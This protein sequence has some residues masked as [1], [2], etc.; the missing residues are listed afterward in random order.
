[1]PE[2]PTKQSSGHVTTLAPGLRV[3]RCDNPGPLT[4]TG[5]NTYLLG[6]NG[7]AV[8]DPG[9]DGH[10]DHL[11]AIMQ[12]CP[13]IEAILV[14][15][16]HRDHSP[17]ARALSDRTGAP[18]HAF[19]DAQAGR[20]TVMQRLAQAHDLGG[21]EGTDVDFVPDVQLADGEALVGTDWEVEAIWTPGHFGNHLSFATE[22]GI[23]SGDLVM[24]W[25]TTLISP[26]DGDLG[27]FRRSC[28]RLLARGSKR[29]FP[30]HGDPVD[31]GAAR[32]HW[33]LEHRAL[34]ENQILDALGPG[35]A[36]PRALTEAIYHDTPTSLWP[37]A[38]R[39]VLAHLIDLI[40]RDKVVTGGAIGP[41]AT[42]AV[43]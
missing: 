4:G 21:G 9:P 7:I 32:I 19:G 35:P 24:G 16:A 25:A 14:T 22:H 29:L 40:E 18:V 12:A 43:P 8:V 30:G 27:A 39:N 37:A 20:S 1:M 26:P 36:T 13:R 3:I 42:Y 41:D 23:L 6:K 28:E 38:S 34:R 31:D 2:L 5:T 15:H 33:L 17:A 10:S 11:D